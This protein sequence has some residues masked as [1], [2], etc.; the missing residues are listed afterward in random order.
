MWENPINL[1]TI[2]VLFFILG[3]LMFGFVLYFN[4][5]LLAWGLW[6][7]GK[8]CSTYGANTN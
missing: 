8:Y 3:F 6:N 2:I 5:G 7:V 4:L 1:I